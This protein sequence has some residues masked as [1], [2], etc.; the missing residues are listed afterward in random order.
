MDET[1]ETKLKHHLILL[2]LDPRLASQLTSL[3]LKWKNEGGA[4]QAV[5]RLKQ[6]KLSL[7][8]FWA[9]DSDCLSHAP[10]FRRSKD[11][12]GLHG[13][14]RH[15]FRVKASKTFLRR[16][17]SIV[18]SYTIFIDSD[19][20]ARKKSRDSIK[21]ISDSYGGDSISL[22]DDFNIGIKI[23]SP[24]ERIKPKPHGIAYLQTWRLPS[25]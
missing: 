16:A 1:I 23:A 11:K 12:K 25:Q 5:E 17:S 18:N 14:F 13:P 4:I 24:E 9:G 7:V 2:D 21:F 8:H 19:K 22:P 10:W 15:L 3:D 20:S 6:V